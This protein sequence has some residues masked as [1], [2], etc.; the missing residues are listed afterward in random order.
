M[1]RIDV[2]SVD[3]VMEYKDWRSETS[4]KA[5]RGDHDWELRKISEA[6]K[7]M[8]RKGG[9]GGSCEELQEQMGNEEQSLGSVV[10]AVADRR[11]G[12]VTIEKWE[13]GSE[14]NEVAAKTSGNVETPTLRV[15]RLTG[16]I[17]S[18][19]KKNGGAGASLSSSGPL[20]C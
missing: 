16:W 8:R 5:R 12:F 15:Q 1:T 18:K 10:Q 11:C 20:M 7:S 17:E 2:N 13:D 14:R 9:P 3:P 6:G 19:D 4:A